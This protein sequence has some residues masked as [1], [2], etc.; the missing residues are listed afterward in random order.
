MKSPKSLNL[1]T[2]NQSFYRRLK[3]LKLRK[4]SNPGDLRKSRKNPDGQKTVK[5]QNFLKVYQILVEN[6]TLDFSGF[7]NSDPDPRD[8]GI[9][10]PVQIRK[11]LNKGFRKNLIPK[12]TLLQIINFTLADVGSSI[13]PIF[14]M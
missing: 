9:F 7:S 5:I 10:D 1:L 3:I 2:S 12:P 14:S 6:S 13:E 4:I 11:I 8:F